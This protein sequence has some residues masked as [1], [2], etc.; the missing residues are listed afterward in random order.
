MGP[1]AE[2]RIECIEAVTTPEQLRVELDTLRDLLSKVL[3]QRQAEQAWEQLE[4]TL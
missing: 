3:P 4:P 2:Y 1:A